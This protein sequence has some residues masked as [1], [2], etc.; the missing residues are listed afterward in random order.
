MRRTILAT[1]ITAGASASLLF[2]GERRASASF[3]DAGIDAGFSKRS[4]ADTSYKPGFAWQLHAELALLPPILM[5][6]PYATFDKP[7]PDVAGSAPDNIAFRTFGLRAKL[8][9]P[10]PGGVK[11]YGVAGIGWTHADFPD[12]TFKACQPTIQGAPPVCVTKPLPNATANFVEFVLGAGLQIDLFGPLVLNAEFDWRPTTGYKNQDYQNAL[13][14]K[15]SGGAPE[16][17][18]N[19][20]VWTGFLGLALSL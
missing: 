11:P 9:L 16:P 10:I 4:L 20:V 19:G 13:E 2:A 5:I 18:R 15:G 7:S 14:Q 8:K 1:L 6:G 17:G 3:L 12:F